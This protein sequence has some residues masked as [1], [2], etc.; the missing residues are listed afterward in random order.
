MQRVRVSGGDLCTVVQKHRPSWQ[1]RQWVRFI[2]H[3]GIEKKLGHRV[4]AFFRRFSF[5]ARR[6]YHRTA[7]ARKKTKFSSISRSLPACRNLLFGLFLHAESIVRLCTMLFYSLFSSWYSLEN[8]VLIL[9]G[10]GT[11]ISVTLSG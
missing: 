2:A 6:Q 5:F 1:A 4:Q 11:P 9:S 7:P 3:R 10:I 8:S